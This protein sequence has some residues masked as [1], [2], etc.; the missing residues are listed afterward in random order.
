MGEGQVSRPLALKVLSFFLVPLG[1]NRAAQVAI[2]RTQ[3]H[4]LALAVERER[5]KMRPWKYAKLM[6]LSGIPRFGLARKLGWMYALLI[7]LCVLTWTVGHVYCVLLNKH[8]VTRKDAVRYN[9]WF[10]IGFICPQVDALLCVAWA[11][12]EVLHH[13]SGLH[14]S[15]SFLSLPSVESSGS[16]RQ[17][18]QC[19]GV[20]LIFVTLALVLVRVSCLLYYDDGRHGLPILACGSLVE[21]LPH[22]PVLLLFQSQVAGMLETHRRIS[23]IIVHTNITPK[24]TSQVCD[25]FRDYV[26]SV[27]RRWVLY[28]FVS[29][30]TEIWS[31][32]FQTAWAFQNMDGDSY[33]R[34]GC[35][36]QMSMFAMIQALLISFKV[37]PMAAYNTR[38]STFPKQIVQRTVGLDSRR[39]SG[40]A[41]CNVFTTD[42]PFFSVCGV[43]VTYAKVLT[44][45]AS[46][47]GSQCV[48]LFLS[49]AFKPSA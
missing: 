39:E 7:V 4:T 29:N 6:L 14:E 42:P 38:I 12:I 15:N 28:T 21:F 37:W 44:M 17:S 25:S 8:E 22:C 34:D 2:N 13:E 45:L 18:R 10:K 36:L 30:F 47:F 31:I 5:V 24:Q 27:S 48:H 9:V 33:H 11:H 3:R 32:V 19:F 20:C 23:D 43:T 40:V 16:S 35:V 26:Q 1:P 49:N 46:V 41:A